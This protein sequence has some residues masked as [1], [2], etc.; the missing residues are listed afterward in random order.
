MKEMGE[1]LHELFEVGWVRT[2]VGY[3]ILN[4][5]EYLNGGNQ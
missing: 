4:R 5:D 2:G 1:R 3:G